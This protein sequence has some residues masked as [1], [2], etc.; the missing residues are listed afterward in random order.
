L[1][2]LAFFRPAK[3]GYHRQADPLVLPLRPLQPAYFLGL[4]TA[5]AAL[6]VQ[7]QRKA[8]VVQHAEESKSQAASG[9]TVEAGDLG[10][11]WASNPSTR[12]N[13]L[14]G[15]MFLMASWCE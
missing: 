5:K 1:D 2:P 3:M 10:K 12:L 14:H 9:K 7:S 8:T 11:F 6:K 15:Q 4:P 13:S